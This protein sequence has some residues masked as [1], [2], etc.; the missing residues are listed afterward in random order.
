M[1]KD[2]VARIEWKFVI[3]TYMEEL[4]V[5]TWKPT[6]GDDIERRKKTNVILIVPGF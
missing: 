3:E 4:L 1:D 5:S 6:G 2:P